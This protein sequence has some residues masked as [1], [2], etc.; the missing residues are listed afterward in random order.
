MA[1]KNET[2]SIV[3]RYSHGFRLLKITRSSSTDFYVS[4]TILFDLLESELT[5]ST[6]EIAL[7]RR[8]TE[9]QEY[10]KMGLTTAAEAERYER[11][12]SQRVCFSFASIEPRADL[13]PY[14]SPPNNPASETRFHW[15]TNDLPQS[16][17]DNKPIPPIEEH[18]SPVQQPRASLS[19]PRRP[20]ISSHH[21]RK[22]FAQHFEFSLDRISILKKS[23]CENG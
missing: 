10:R 15:V 16:D 23:S 22:N 11:D 13:L 1:R 9:L 21:S 20:Y 19:P 6:D 3:L 8:I 17:L 5:R 18:S 4:L 14:R 2:S 12:K 7:R